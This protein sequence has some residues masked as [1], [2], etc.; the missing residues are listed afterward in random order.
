MSTNLTK[1]NL[2]L[3]AE[4]YQYLLTYVYPSTD[5]L[6]SLHPGAPIMPLQPL[7]QACP[8]LLHLASFRTPIARL[9]IPIVA[10]ELSHVKAFAAYFL[11]GSN[12]CHD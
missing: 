5:N 2:E 9:R 10:S 1:I 8:S 4:L 6:P 7:S 3:V 11:A 12:P